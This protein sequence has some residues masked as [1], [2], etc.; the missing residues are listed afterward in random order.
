MA[1]RATYDVADNGCEPRS[2][3]DLLQDPLDGGFPTQAPIQGN[4]FGRGL[5]KKTKVSPM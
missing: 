4:V 1:Q 5:M 3:T 2:G